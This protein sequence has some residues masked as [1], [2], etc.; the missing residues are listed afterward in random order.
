MHSP[1]ELPLSCT[2]TSQLDSIRLASQNRQLNS[3]AHL[4]QLCRLLDGHQ[5]QVPLPSH[6]LLLQSLSQQQLQIRRRRCM[7]HFEESLLCHKSQCLRCLQR[8]QDGTKSPLC[9]S[10]ML[11]SRS[12]MKGLSCIQC[13]VQSVCESTSS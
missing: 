9:Q 2:C 8:R 13:C 3:L 4:C 1:V 7:N 6:L 12:L 5:E 11:S 10:R